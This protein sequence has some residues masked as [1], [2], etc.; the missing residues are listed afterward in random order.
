MDF[1]V[2]YTKL[3]KIQLPWFIERVEVNEPGNRVD[4]W[5]QKDSWE[6]KNERAGARSPSLV[7]IPSQRQAEAYATCQCGNILGA[8]NAAGAGVV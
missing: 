6:G 7:V 8:E 2:L 4:V 5:V 3:L 1:N